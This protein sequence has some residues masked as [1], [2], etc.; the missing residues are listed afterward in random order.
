MNR[1]S[2]KE[3][4]KSQQKTLSFFNPKKAPELLPQEEAS[5]EAEED[6]SGPDGTDALV[7]GTVEVPEPDANQEPTL[8]ETQEAEG[9]QQSVPLKPPSIKKRQRSLSSSLRLSSSQ[10]FVEDPPPKRG[11][12]RPP[13]SSK[14]QT[15]DEPL[16]SVRPQRLV[17]LTQEEEQRRVLCGGRKSYVTNQKMH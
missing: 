15:K 13:G 9:S 2:L 4:G 11:P 5:A 3:A 8:E 1:H 14:A 16:V 12:G 7:E 6:T 10:E 17:D